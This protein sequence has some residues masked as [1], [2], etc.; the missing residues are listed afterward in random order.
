MVNLKKMTL[1]MFLLC[2]SAEN[3]Y[4]MSV[5]QAQSSRVFLKWSK[6][7][8][9]NRSL[10]NCEVR[11]N[12][13]FNQ[14]N[15][16]NFTASGKMTD[17]GDKIGSETSTRPSCR[18]TRPWGRVLLHITRCYKKGEKRTARAVLSFQT[19]ANHPDLDG[20]Y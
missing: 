7:C 1:L 17:P 18:K 8:K 11:G 5:T 15:D 6:T 10:S 19:Q 16:E 13:I 2:L 14:A 4:P 9:F 3:D 12:N 20:C